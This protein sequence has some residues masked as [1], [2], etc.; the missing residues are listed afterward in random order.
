MARLPTSI[1][2]LPR[3]RC[4]VDDALAVDEVAVRTDLGD[5]V[6]RARAQVDALVAR[7]ATA[8]RAAGASDV[9]RR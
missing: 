7:V 2:A 9:D 3:L 4:V 1:A 5:A 8:W 6:T